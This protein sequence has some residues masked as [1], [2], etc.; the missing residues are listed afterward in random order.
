MPEAE[1]PI[2]GSVVDY[3]PPMSEARST[4]A[5]LTPELILDAVERLGRFI[6][7]LHAVGAARPFRHRPA[8]DV[9]SFG[10]EPSRFL[11]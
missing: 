1:T 10:G 2:A 9:E 5:R 7:R 6:G 4:Y 3:H 11:L 8:L